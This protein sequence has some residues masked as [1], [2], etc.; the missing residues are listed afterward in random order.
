M[1]D[2][3]ELYNWSTMLSGDSALKK[4]LDTV[5]CSLCYI[6]PQFFKTLLEWI[7]VP[8]HFDFGAANMALGMVMTD[9]HK[10]STQQHFRQPEPNRESMTDDSKEASN[11]MSE[12]GVAL[13]VGNI[14]SPLDSSFQLSQLCLGEPRLLTL[15]M[16]CQSP[17]ALQMLLNSGL[18]MILCQGLF[19]F[20]TREM[21]RH[22]AT[23][24]SSMEGMTDACKS[25]G[26]CSDKD[27]ALDIG[28]SME[29]SPSE[30]MVDSQSS[31]NGKI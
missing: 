29:Q 23:V 4:A 19:E 26:V 2:F 9:D 5:V 24:G 30:P 18:P 22:N 25:A 11:A 14:D 8:S 3:S 27:S 20:C 15:G 6:Q 12:S 21:I 28:S 10:D 16:A 17:Q 1:Y 7:G 13:D 31:T